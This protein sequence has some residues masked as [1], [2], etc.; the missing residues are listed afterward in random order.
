MVST[1]LNKELIRQLVAARFGSV[2][3]L[4]VEWEERVTAGVQRVG[5][6]RDRSTVYRWMEKGLPSN[7]DDFFGFASVLD[8]DPVALLDFDRVDVQARMANE[9]RLLYAGLTQQSPLSP[10]W[11]LYTPGS[12][13][14]SP[15]IATTYYGRP[16]CTQEFIHD[17]AKFAN[18]YAAV[19]LQPT[20]VEEP[21]APRTFHFA[22]R[23]SGY[24]DDAWRPYGSVIGN[25]NE[26][27]LVSE[28]GDYQKLPDE[29]SP[30]VVVAETYFGLGPADFR[31][32]SLH[33]FSVSLDVPSDE[34][35]VVRFVA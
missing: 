18:V 19:H 9:R 1:P 28:S 17:P 33:R 20:A 11:P 3:E 25:V 32:A 26:V 4:M 31:I 7:R 34:H 15:T 2:D 29:R 16:W 8:V 10:F 27:R 6:A 24:A 30:R 21:P 23:R 5:R 14:P 13:W 12:I 22:Y 35:A